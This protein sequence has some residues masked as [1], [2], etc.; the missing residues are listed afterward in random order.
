M[1]HFVSTSVLNLKQASAS[2]YSY[3]Y[4]LI[5]HLVML[6]AKSILLHLRTCFIPSYEDTSVYSETPLFKPNKI[7][8]V[9]Y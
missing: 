8:T 1:Q 2:I 3:F 5:K 7:R 4:S 6:V 9:L